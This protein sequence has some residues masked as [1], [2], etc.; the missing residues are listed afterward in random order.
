[1]PSSRG[2]RRAGTRSRIG[3]ELFSD[4]MGPAGSYEGTYVG[5]I[6]NNVTV[7]ARALGGEAAARHA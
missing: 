3:G 6:D 2:R 4:A 7:I 1:M 5:M